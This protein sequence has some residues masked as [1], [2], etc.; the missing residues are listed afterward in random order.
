[1]QCN[2]IE[3]Q[4]HLLYA[5]KECGSMG[6]LRVLHIGRWVLGWAW[7]RC[8]RCGMWTAGRIRIIKDQEGQP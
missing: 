7:S 5:C 3:R 4:G 2:V 6:T 1:M 8:R